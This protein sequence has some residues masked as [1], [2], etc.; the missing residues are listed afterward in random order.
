LD[1]QGQYDIA[2]VM[3]EH[4]AEITKRVHPADAA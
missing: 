3:R 4:G 2:V 1:L